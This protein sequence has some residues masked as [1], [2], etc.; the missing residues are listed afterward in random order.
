MHLIVNIGLFGLNAI[1]TKLVAFVLMPIYTLYLSTSEYGILDMS[2]IVIGLILPVVTLSITSGVLRFVIDDKEHSAFY[3]TEGIIINTISCILV[4]ALLPLLDLSV[5]GGLGQYKLWFLLCYI[6]SVFS[7]LFYDV[8]RALDQMK[9][10]A[11]SALIASVVMG[12]LTVF[13][14]MSLQW[15]LEG[16]FSAYA[17]GFAAQS[18]IL[19]IGGRHYKYCNFAE[20]AKN[21][22]LRRQLFKYSA[23]LAP[24]SIFWYTGTAFSRFII[25]GVLGV[26]ASGLYAAASRVPNLLNALQQVFQQAWQISSFQ[27][28]RKSDITGFYNNV[29][30]MYFLVLTCGSSLI[31]VLTPWLSSF[32][33]NKEFHSAWT[34]IP[35]L[36]V[37]FLIDAFNNFYGTIYQVY[38]KTKPLLITT[39]IGAAVCV[40]FTSTFVASIGI[41]AAALGLL[42]GNIVIGV[43]RFLHIK[44]YLPLKIG[45][46]STAITVSLLGIQVCVTTITCIHYKLYSIAGFILICLV[47]IVVLVPILS[48]FRSKLSEHNP[49][50]VRH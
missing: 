9:L 18:L 27:E 13:F 42:L 19:F 22:H 26:S 32:L 6:M 10:M 3:V 33:L 45:G 2:I 4:A 34:L 14:L 39:A 31:I 8:A 38:M 20:W 23:P 7:G 35:T 15:K 24:S 50:I 43:I 49:P 17:I 28:Y 16:Y 25:T 21:Q 37:A 41:F 40:S 1:V 36:I 44:R 12:G 11:S 47:Q 46:M 30:R 5:F 48:I 29:W